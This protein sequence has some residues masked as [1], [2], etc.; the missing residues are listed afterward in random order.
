MCVRPMIEKCRPPRA[1]EHACTGGAL[2]LAPVA[3]ACGGVRALQPDRLLE[4]LQAVQG[5]LLLQRQMPEV[6]PSQPMISCLE[7]SEDTS[8]DVLFVMLMINCYPE[9][10]KHAMDH[11]FCAGSIGCSTSLSALDVATAI[12]ERILHFWPS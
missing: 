3:E 2:S 8:G 9:K 5:C 12:L 10:A 4:Q 6:S 7:C 11:D 1:S